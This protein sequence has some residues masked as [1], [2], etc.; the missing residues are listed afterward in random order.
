MK[1]ILI[2][3]L[4]T[5]SVMN[6]DDTKQILNEIKQLRVDMNKRFEQVDKRF[7]QVDKRFESMQS[8]LDKRF[9]QVDKR[10]DFMQNILYALM[11]LIFASPF[12]AIYLRDKRELE[13]KKYFDNIKSML[14]VFRE[15]AQDDE[16]LAKSLRA[17][18]L[19]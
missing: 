11:G 13:Q 6:A 7:E 5:Y 4:F 14:F 8:N 16:K 17:A 1:K 3:L 19:L 10:L 15:Q 12:I 9:E 18:G 2:I